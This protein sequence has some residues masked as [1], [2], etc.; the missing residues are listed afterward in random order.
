MNDSDK[1]IKGCEYELCDF[2]L[3]YK[4]SELSYC[5]GIC[6]IDATDTEAWMTC[7]K[8]R[9]KC[10]LCLEETLEHWCAL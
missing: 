7:R 10:K 4:N 5:A 3:W 2:C 8:G 9:F 1:E 6:A